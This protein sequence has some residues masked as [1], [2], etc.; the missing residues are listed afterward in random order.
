M[1]EKGFRAAGA[2]FKKEA[3][4]K[5]GISRLQITGR[6]G[7]SHWNQRTLTPGKQKTIHV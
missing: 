6:H 7:S 3:Q 2:V 4:D 5:K 1:E